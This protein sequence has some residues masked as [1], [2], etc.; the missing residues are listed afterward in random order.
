VKG[1]ALNKQFTKGIEDNT[2]NGEILHYA[3]MNLTKLF[4]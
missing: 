4:I 2:V 1:D 3:A